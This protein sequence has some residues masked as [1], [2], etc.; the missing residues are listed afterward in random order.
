MSHSKRYLL[1]GV[2]NGQILYGFQNFKN[3]IEYTVNVALNEF[4]P[5]F[6]SVKDPDYEP[7]HSSDNDSDSLFEGIV[8]PF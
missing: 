8:C 4:Y 6:L 1:I 7:D 3:I 5:I 2:S